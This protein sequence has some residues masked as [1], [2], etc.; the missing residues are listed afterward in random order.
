[1]KDTEG[2]YLLI[3]RQYEKL[4]HVSREAVRTLTDYDIFPK[5][6][7]DAFRAHD[8]RVLQEAVPIEFDEVAMHDDGP[9]DYI[10]IK[11][12]LLDA[13]GKPYAV[14]GISTD[15]TDR[16]K[17]AE[18]LVRNEAK[19][20]VLFESSRDAIM[21]LFPPDWKFTSANSATIALFGAKDE[22][23]FTSLGPW[24]VSPA[25]QPDGEPSVDK[26]KRM[27]QTAVE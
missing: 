1:V 26:A 14:C 11:F 6:L 12:P 9:H 25:R 19:Y 22:K 15:I 13:A 16:K 27:I 5:D 10:S 21:T 17:I 23:E 2:R 3:N 4:F 8:L 7:A 20:R 18:A 24:D